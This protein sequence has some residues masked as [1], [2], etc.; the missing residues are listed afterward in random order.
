MRSASRSSLRILLYVLPALVLLAPA[1][2]LTAITRCVS[3]TPTTGCYTS[4]DN[5]LI[6][7]VNG[8]VIQVRQGT[9]IGPV[10]ITKSITLQAAP[11]SRP[12]IDATGKPN[13]IVIGFPRHAPVTST[14]PSIQ[15]VSNVAVQGFEVENAQFEGILAVNVSLVTLLQNYVH[16]NDKALDPSAG[17]CPGL[18]TEIETNEQQDCGGGIHLMGA[19]QSSVFGNV[20][21][22]NASGILLSDDTQQ[23][24]YDQITNN[25]VHDN[26][27]G[28]GIAIASNPPAPLS[29]YK[30]GKSYVYLVYTVTVD[31]NQSYH[32]G[33]RSGTGAG[34][35]IFALGSGNNAFQIT[36]SYNDLGE[37][38]GPGLVMH[39]NVASLYFIAVFGNNQ[40]INN[41]I[42]GNGPDRSNPASS[43][44]TG[45][46]V[47][48][49][50]QAF[51]V[52]QENE[53]SKEATDI[54]Y[55]VPAGS[56]LFNQFNDLGDDR[57]VGI[58]YIG[59]QDPFSGQ[60]SLFSLDASYNWW[61]CPTGASANCRSILNPGGPVNG[62]QYQVTSSPALTE[63]FDTRIRW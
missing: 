61:G 34:I 18:N 37:N 5:A 35:G 52:I 36:A 63:H 15:T 54:A 57:G 27:Y 16:D 26:G 62:V 43:S 41:R 33:T 24:S 51:A 6:A 8:D 14:D 22:N 25:I 17:T 30:P 56:F 46:S 38:A 29:T 20:V 1:D 40:I 55:A 4:I 2:R 39:N 60:P 19:Y 47:H 9:Y 21:E 28:S 23:S 3:A 50:G 12:I 7:A 59:T 42:H 48:A 10:S 45:I 32:N 58:S 11:N 13:G 49:A 44:S 31:R 53:F